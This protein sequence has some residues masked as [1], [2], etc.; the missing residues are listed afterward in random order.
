MGLI[1]PLGTFC[2][3]DVLSLGRFVPWDVLSLGVL[4]LGPYVLGRFVLGRFLK[5]HKKCYSKSLHPTEYSL[6]TVHLL[7]MVLEQLW[8][9]VFHPIYVTLFPMVLLVPAVSRGE[10]EAMRGHSRKSNWCRIPW[11]L[12]YLRSVYRGGETISRDTHRHTNN[13]HRETNRSVKLS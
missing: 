9:P 3:W 7:L 10:N 1:C 11:A 12:I 8:L 5:S 6:L 4:S 2:P 13:Q